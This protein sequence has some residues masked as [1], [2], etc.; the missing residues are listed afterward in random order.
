MDRLNKQMTE[1]YLRKGDAA[2]DAG[3]RGHMPG[4]GTFGKR[5][6]DARAVFCVATVLAATLFLA[7]CGISK[8]RLEARETGI[9]LLE[10]GDYDGAIAQFEELIAGATQ[11]TDFETDILKYRAKA[12]FL[13]GDAE[14]AAY[15]YDILNQ[16]DEKK[17]E[18][19]YLG[20]LCLAKNGDPEGA[21]RQ[22]DAGRELDTH[23]ERPGFTEA[24]E[25]LAAAY[26]DAKDESGAEGVYHELIVLGINAAKNYNRLAL[27]AIRRGEY[28][29][30]LELIAEG[31]AADD[32]A[33]GE[34]EAAG[35]GD[36]ADN[37]AAGAGGAAGQG[38]SA[39]QGSAASG[40]AGTDQ[41]FAAGNAKRDLR[42]NEA[43]CYEYLG[44]FE[45]ALELFRNYV[46]EFGSDKKAEHEIA[47]LETR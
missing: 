40:T 3:R 19:C 22:I 8:E 7:G 44:D 27:A 2:K 6:L 39:G 4:R 42:F 17:A 1:K 35:Q 9:A 14:A 37:R 15:T 31:L 47:F 24:M 41:D 25:A 29:Q 11:V 13:S 26:T 32:G 12:E 38:D 18:Y 45:R 33:V 21:R 36:S 10:S 46:S 30:A 16:V 43:V 23:A 5:R 34:G 28:E 20:A